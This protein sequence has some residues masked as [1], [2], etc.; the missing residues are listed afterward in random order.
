M[1]FS[2]GGNWAAFRGNDNRIF[3]WPASTHA[4]G[5]MLDLGMPQGTT[6]VW[7]DMLDGDEAVLNVEVWNSQ[8]VR[9]SEVWRVD[10][11]MTYESK[12]LVVTEQRVFG[13]QQLRKMALLSKDGTIVVAPFEKHWKSWV[14][15]NSHRE[16]RSCDSEPFK[17]ELDVFSTDDFDHPCRVFPLNPHT[18][19]QCGC[20]CVVLWDY[21]KHL[22]L[23]DAETGAWLLRQPLRPPPDV[24]LDPYALHVDWS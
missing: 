2:S 23:C 7:V 21:S 16:L 19:F 1:S 3:L 13:R 6:V 20:G 24:E 8:G 11:K 22:D 10:L 14:A 5:I 17:R 15:V 9:Q 18:R 4:E 12:E